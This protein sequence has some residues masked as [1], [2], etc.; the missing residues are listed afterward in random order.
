[1]R[2]LDAAFLR[3]GAAIFLPLPGGRGED[4]SGSLQER[5]AKQELRDE[6]DERT[7]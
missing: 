4:A 6:E 3:R 7:A 1:V 5:I 2:R